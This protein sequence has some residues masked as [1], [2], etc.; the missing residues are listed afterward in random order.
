M[1][2][3]SKTKKGI[4]VAVMIV[5]LVALI[6]GTYARY[7]STGTANVSASIAKWHIELNDTNISTASQTVSVPLIYATNE[8]VANG[9]LAP[10]RTATL[11]LEI[12]PTGSE[13]AVDYTFDIDSDAIA[14]ALEL[15]STSAITLTGATY[16]VGSGEAQTATINNGIISLSESLSDVEAGKAV[17][18]VVTLAWD[19]ASDANNSSDTLEGVASYNT[20]ETTGKTITIPVTVTA[21]QHI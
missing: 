14:E 16:T 12:D 13:V 18:V 11:T 4:L 7:S 5:C 9:K 10:G 19:N 15:N 17:T 8:Y 6:A 2:R 21:T 3:Q 1:N 20:Q